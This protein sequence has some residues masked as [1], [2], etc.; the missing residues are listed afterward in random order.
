[1]NTELLT[2][3]NII[4]DHLFGLFYADGQSSGEIKVDISSRND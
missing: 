2:A 1:M 3:T 4:V